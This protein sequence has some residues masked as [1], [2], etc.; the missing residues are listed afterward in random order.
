MSDLFPGPGEHLAAFAWVLAAG[1]MAGVL[2]GMAVGHC[3]RFS[4]E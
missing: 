3:S 1:V 2:L 4:D